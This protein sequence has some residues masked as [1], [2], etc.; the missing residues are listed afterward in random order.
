[1]SRSGTQKYLGARR[2][3]HLPVGSL[4]IAFIDDGRRN[5]HDAALAAGR[6]AR[7]LEYLDETA[8]AFELRARLLRGK[9]S[10]ENEVILDIQAAGS[11]AV[12]IHLGGTHEGNAI[13]IDQD[14]VRLLSRSLAD[15]AGDHAGI[16]VPDAIEGGEI[17]ALNQVLLD[18][19]LHLPELHGVAGA[20]IK[21]FPIENGLVTHLVNDGLV[22]MDV[23]IRLTRQ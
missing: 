18:Q 22:I 6:D 9:K 20:D 7:A 23:I 3:Y 2:C 17:G 4:H 10:I 13:G 16:V 15:D 19:T 1:M 8:R 11:K 21:A 14:D 12:E 5:Q